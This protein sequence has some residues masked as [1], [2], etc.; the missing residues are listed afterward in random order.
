MPGKQK[1]DIRQ[2]STFSGGCLEWKQ[3]SKVYTVHWLWWELGQ[4]LLGN[5]VLF[6]LSLIVEDNGWSE[7]TWSRWWECRIPLFSTPNTFILKTPNSPSLSH[8]PQCNLPLVPLRQLQ[9]W[10]VGPQIFIFLTLSHTPIFKKEAMLESTALFWSCNVLLD[11][12]H[13]NEIPEK[14]TYKE[15]ALIWAHGFK[16]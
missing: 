12:W 15:K 5:S 8:Q 3:G 13:C 11:S 10:A 16:G 14:G 4:R 9:G 6:W 1:R 7:D 2:L